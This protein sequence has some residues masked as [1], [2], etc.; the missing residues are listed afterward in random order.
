MCWMIADE[1]DKCYLNNSYLCKLFESYGLKTLINEVA[2]PSK[3]QKESKAANIYYNCGKFELL[4][5]K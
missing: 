1:L 5:T 2:K 4:Q 3:R